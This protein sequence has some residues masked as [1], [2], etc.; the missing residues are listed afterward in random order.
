MTK[1]CKS[2]K[3]EKL[4]DEFFNNKSGKYGKEPRCK[5]CRK[6]YLLHDQKENRKKYYQKNKEKIKKKNREYE[7]NNVDKTRENHK[8][9]MKKRRSEDINFRLIDNYRSRINVALKGEAK[10]ESFI[11]LLGCSIEEF[12]LY[13][14]KQF[15]E[16]MN[17]DN[18]GK[19]KYWEIDHTIPLSKG[20]SFHYTNTSPM[21]ILQNRS[22]SNKFFT[23]EEIQNTSK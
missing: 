4:L 3:E 17:W 15:N 9:Y 8:N 20:G 7:L 10:E 12:K 6:Y 16:N 14:E 22:K 19:D 13:L 2:C 5:L 21:P 1:I 23:Q 11:Q 18:Y